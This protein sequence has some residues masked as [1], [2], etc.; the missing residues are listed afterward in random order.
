MFCQDV[1]DIVFGNFDNEPFDHPTYLF[2]EFLVG[3]ARG[4]CHDICS[5]V[6][7]YDDVFVRASEITDKIL[8]SMLKCEWRHCVDHLSNEYT[9]NVITTHKRFDE[10]I[11]DEQLV[12]YIKDMPMQEA[13][14]V[15]N[16]PWWG[17]DYII[18]YQRAYTKGKSYSREFLTNVESIPE[19]V[20]YNLLED[21]IRNEDIEF[22]RS[23]TKKSNADQIYFHVEQDTLEMNNVEIARMLRDYFGTTSSID[24]LWSFHHLEI[25]KIF[26]HH[27]DWTESTL[28]DHIHDCAACQ[29]SPDIISYWISHYEALFQK[30]FDTCDTVRFSLCEGNVE[31]FKQYFNPNDHSHLNY[32]NEWADETIH[33]PPGWHRCAAVY[34][35]IEYLHSLGLF[36]ITPEFIQEFALAGNFSTTCSLYELY[37]RQQK[38]KTG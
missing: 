3:P 12:H 8:M 10:V 34:A 38:N 26:S 18:L 24:S 25:Q 5:F 22:I 29:V 9:F 20:F 35:K 36:T 21:A 7:G 2:I 6:H 30:P 11:Q 27:F 28:A 32:A 37:E 1:A 16:E 17:N 15:F 19:D 31:V 13:A 33:D 23:L 4:L 14:L